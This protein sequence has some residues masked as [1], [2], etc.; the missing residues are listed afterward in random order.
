MTKKKPLTREQVLSKIME[1][2]K[3]VDEIQPLAEFVEV[4]NRLDDTIT[5]IDAAT[6]KIKNLPALAKRFEAA[7]SAI[8]GLNIERLDKAFKDLPVITEVLES[9]R[10]EFLQIDK[11]LN[12]VGR[13]I[14]KDENESD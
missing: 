2:T 14:A 3:T 12:K 4:F 7:V 6:V 10:N 13:Q 1:Y 11:E 5:T 9:K 8:K